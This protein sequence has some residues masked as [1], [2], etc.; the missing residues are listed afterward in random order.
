MTRLTEQELTTALEA[1]TKWAIED[2]M[3]TRT[4]GFA[5]FVAAIAF[6]DRVAVAAEEAQHHPDIDIRYNRVR[7]ALTTHDEGGISNKDLQLAD[8]LDRL[9]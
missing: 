2:A 6:V 5:D 3:L 4:Y 9:A 8:R 1:R 7:I